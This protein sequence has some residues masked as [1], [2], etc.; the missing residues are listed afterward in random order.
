MA[1]S[2]RLARLPNQASKPSCE[3]AASLP[4]ALPSWRGSTHLPH[5]T[6]IPPTSRRSPET[7]IQKLLLDVS[8]AADIW[9]SRSLAPARDDD[10]KAIC[11]GEQ[12]HDAHFVGQN[13][14]DDADHQKPETEHQE[15]PPINAFSTPPRFGREHILVRL[16]HDLNPW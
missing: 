3:S 5:N 12:Y 14:R 16:D 4:R 8:T 2:R 11:Q 15:H 9:K 7:G 1:K 6:V 13:N 10:H